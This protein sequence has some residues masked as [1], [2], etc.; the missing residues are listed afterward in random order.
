MTKNAQAILAAAGMGESS[1]LNRVSA[2]Y[3]PRGQCSLDIEYTGGGGKGA[4]GA[5]ISANYFREW[6]RDLAQ[7]GLR[8][9]NSHVAGDRSVTLMIDE[10]SAI[11]RAKPGAVKGWSFDHCNLVAPQDIPR[12]AKLQ[13]MFSC[14]ASN[15]IASDPSR[16]ARSPLVAYGEDVLHKYAAPFKTMIDAGINVS[17]EEEGFPWWLGIETLVTRTDPQG[18]VW[19]PQERVDRMTALRIATQNGANYIL[20]GDQLGS[21][22]SGK[23]AD[24]VVLDGDYLTMP[25]EQIRNI[26]P[27]MTM[28]GGRMRFLRTDFAT[29]YNLKPAGAVISTHDELL[30]R[31]PSED[32]ASD[33][34]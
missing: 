29:E 9:S 25:V 28:M 14:K 33:E 20:K 18:K 7:N 1:D 2:E 21:I 30:K 32:Q 19:G 26:R 3:F 34:R 10:W 13:L 11:D 22:E 16:G 17:L 8:S 23:L 24:L 27:V 5:R 15:A 4:K 6:Y 31:R 12:A